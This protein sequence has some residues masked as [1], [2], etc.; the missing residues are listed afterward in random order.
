MI[1]PLIC[2]TDER[3]HFL[4]SPNFKSIQ[5]IYIATQICVKS[6]KIIYPKIKPFRFFLYQFSLHINPVYI[7]NHSFQKPQF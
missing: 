3:T 4:S 2:L 6:P 7:E 1:A 5:T